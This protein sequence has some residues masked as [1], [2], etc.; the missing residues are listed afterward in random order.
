MA[1]AGSAA[2]RISV[3]LEKGLEDPSQAAWCLFW[4]CVLKS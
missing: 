4:G 2:E 3:D 1:D